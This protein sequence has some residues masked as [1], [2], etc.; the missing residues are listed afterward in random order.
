MG[1]NIKLKLVRTIA[2][3][4]ELGFVFPAKPREARRAGRA[5]ALKGNLSKIWGQE[6]AT[7]APALVPAQ[8]TPKQPLGKGLYDFPPCFI[9]SVMVVISF[10]WVRARL[11]ESQGR[12]SQVG[13]K[14]RFR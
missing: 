7:S 9:P 4:P 12:K 8:F 1:K 3:L 11:E 14:M 13:E 2:S 5:P 6:K 10:T